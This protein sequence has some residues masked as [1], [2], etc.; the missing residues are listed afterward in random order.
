G[1][2]PWGP[3]AVRASAGSVLRVPVVTGVE[4]DAALTA[5]RT[6]GMRVVGTDVRRGEAHDG[7]I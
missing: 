6:A 7:G 1:A 4:A 3:K 5:L 2:D